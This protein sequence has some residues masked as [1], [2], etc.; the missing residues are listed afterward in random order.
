MT[1]TCDLGV[2][3]CNIHYAQA[4]TD[5]IPI[6][7]I[8]VRKDLADVD[9]AVVQVAHAASEAIRAAPIDRRTTLR[10]KFVKDEAE[11]LE[12]AVKLVETGVHIA[13][14]REPDAPYNGEATALATEPGTFRL[15]K[16]SK[17]LFLLP[18]ATWM[19]VGEDPAK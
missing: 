14:I 7:Y 19:S 8:L 11:L 6:Q 10:I 4:S 12:Y 13:L 9:D 16:L 15:N 3:D 17:V 2:G 18:R 1:C 5:R